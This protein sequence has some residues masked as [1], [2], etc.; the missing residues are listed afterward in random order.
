ML[1][2]RERRR[3]PTARGINVMLSTSDCTRCARLIS[4]RPLSH[5]RFSFLVARA[6]TLHLWPHRRRLIAFAA[7][8]RAV[9]LYPSSRTPPFLYP[10]AAMS[11]VSGPAIPSRTPHPPLGPSR[12][13]EWPLAAKWLLDAVTDSNQTLPR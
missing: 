8:C 6:V 10:F 2:Y 9:C 1:I 7:M 4:P 11:I 3:S 12:A 5:W 13:L